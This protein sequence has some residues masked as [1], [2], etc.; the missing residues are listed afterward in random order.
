MEDEEEVGVGGNGNVARH[1]T[2]QDL[3]GSSDSTRR[4]VLIR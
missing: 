2:G 3:G 1:G 4:P